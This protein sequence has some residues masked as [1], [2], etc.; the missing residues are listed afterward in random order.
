MGRSR[1]K[2]LTD[3]RLGQHIALSV[4][5]GLARTQ[6][7]PDPLRIYDAQQLAEMFD[8]IARA[9][10][11]VAQLYVRDTP[12]AEPRLLTPE[13][14]AGASVRR[15][16]T[17]IV[18]KDGRTFSSVTMRRG[19]LRQAI[20][21]LK[22]VGIPELQFPRAQEPGAFAPPANG[23]GEDLL[24]L[25]EEMQGLL[26]PPLVASQYEQANRIALTL[27]RK[28]SQGRVS[29][30]AMQLM[31]CLH[32][33]RGADRLPERCAVIFAQLRAALEETLSAP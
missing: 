19:D 23:N 28:A 31:S 13:E 25:V 15:G 33:A 30:L 18:L 12:E 29:N 20:A 4:A 32:E 14:Q 1:T 22:A 17:V 21:V 5:A 9:L 27:A 11:K 16:A 2:Q 10:A 6:F 3:S 8:V 26:T 7:T 24:K